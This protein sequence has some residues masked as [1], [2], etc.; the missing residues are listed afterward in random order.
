MK[1]SVKSAV[2]LSE[3]F[4]LYLAVYTKVKRMFPAHQPSRYGIP[5]GYAQSGQIRWFNKVCDMELGVL[6]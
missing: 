6:Y 1:E 2:Q 3:L 5:N 4:Q